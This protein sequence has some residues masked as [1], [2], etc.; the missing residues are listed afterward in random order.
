MGVVK[1]YLEFIKMETIVVSWGI[2]PV[3]GEW[4]N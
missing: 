2:I 3:S 1:V 4:R